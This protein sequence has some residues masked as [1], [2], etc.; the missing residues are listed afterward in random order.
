[1]R[2]I[3]H[4][5]AKH[6]I[7]REGFRSL[8]NLTPVLNIV[9]TCELHKGIHQGRKTRTRF[10]TVVLRFPSTLLICEWLGYRLKSAPPQRT[11][12]HHVK[13]VQYVEPQEDIFL[14]DKK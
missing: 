4:L 9:L 5:I 3:I 2:I 8:C 6:I 13:G 1:M 10:V 14:A 12:T 7:K 11:V